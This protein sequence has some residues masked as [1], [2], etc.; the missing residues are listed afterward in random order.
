MEFSVD[1]YG[2]LGLLLYCA[3]VVSAS[4]ISQLATAHH[5]VYL[6]SI[7]HLEAYCENQNYNIRVDLILLYPILVIV[8]AWG[9]VTVWLK[10]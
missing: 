10:R 3:C 8:T 6:V 5:C 1:V 4:S 9:I 7:C 2:C